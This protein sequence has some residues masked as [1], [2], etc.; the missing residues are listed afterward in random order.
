MIRQA[1]LT[2]DATPRTRHVLT[3]ENR[4]AWELVVDRVIT[5]YLWSSPVGYWRVVKSTAYGTVTYGPAPVL[6]EWPFGQNCGKPL[7]VAEL[8]HEN[9][10]REIW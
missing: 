2:V 5:E 7:W 9:Y 10:P 6:V 1:T 4:G 3:S 8:E